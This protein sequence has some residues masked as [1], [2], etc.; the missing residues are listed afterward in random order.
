MLTIP[1]R[2]LVTGYKHDGLLQYRIGWVQSEGRRKRDFVGT[3]RYALRCPVKETKM[4][5]ER[6][7]IV[8][9]HDGD[10][11]YATELSP[12]GPDHR[13]SV[14]YAANRKVDPDPH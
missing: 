13:K 9:R 2:H 5:K 10:A 3:V 6:G 7:N 4:S 8:H 11:P 1:R 14:Q 12:R